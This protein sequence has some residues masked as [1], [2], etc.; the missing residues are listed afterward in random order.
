MPPSCS[1]PTAAR[2]GSVPRCTISLT[3]HRGARR[4]SLPLLRPR[5]AAAVHLPRSAPTPCSRCA[6][7]APSSW[8]RCWPSAI[9]RPGSRGWTWTPPAPSGRTS[10]SS[11]PVERGEVD[12]LIGTQMI[13]KGLDFPNVTLVGVVDADIG[14][15]L[16]DFRSAERTFQL[17]AQVAG[18]AGRGPKGGRV[19]VQTRHP[20]ASRAGLGRAARHRGISRAGAR[21]AARRRRIRRRPSLVNLVVSGARRA[22]TGQPGGGGGGLV[23]WAWSAGTSC[24]STVLGPGAVPARPDQGS[25]AVARAAQGTVAR[26]TRPGRAVRRQVTL[27][28]TPGRSRGSRSRPAPACSSREALLRPIS[29]LRSHVDHPPRRRLD[30]PTTQRRSASPTRCTA[31]PT[32][33]SPR[34]TGQS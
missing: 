8:S 20:G 22:R 3:V 31:G 5:G 15:Y 13:A 9:R 32:G 16:P 23:H 7:S 19:L 4:A 29:D 17:L 24:R 12:L 1:A 6:A 10:G 30:H 25:L 27:G 18:R 26:C 33:C 14:L 2:S 11:A 21:A 34:G 28:P